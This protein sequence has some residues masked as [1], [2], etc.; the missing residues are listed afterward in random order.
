VAHTHSETF[1]LEVGLERVLCLARSEVS[2]DRAP[3]ELAGALLGQMPQDRLADRPG[4]LFY[5]ALIRHDLGIRIV[6]RGFR[7]LLPHGLLL[8]FDIFF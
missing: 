3:L 5:N 6:L 8:S 7:I 2:V 1:A 4:V